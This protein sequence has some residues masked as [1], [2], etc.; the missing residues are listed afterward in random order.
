VET[1]KVREIGDRRWRGHVALLGEKRSTHTT[2]MENSGGRETFGRP[3]PKW[4]D[5]IKLETK[6]IK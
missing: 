2:V 1:L 6:E 4:E 3:K 5:N